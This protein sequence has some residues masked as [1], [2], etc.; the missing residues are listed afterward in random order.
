MNKIKETTDVSNNSRKL[1]KNDFNKKEIS[2]A[3]AEAAKVMLVDQKYDF[4]HT[5]LSIRLCEESI[6][7]DEMD[8]M[9]FVDA[10]EEFIDAIFEMSAIIRGEILEREKTVMVRDG[11]DIYYMNFSTIY[12]ASIINK[13]SPEE[14]ENDL[15]ASIEREENDEIIERIK[16]E[17]KASLNITP[18]QEEQEEA[19][20]YYDS[21]YNGV[22]T[23]L[24]Y[25]NPLNYWISTEA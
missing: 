16:G 14:L 12:G 10:S 9:E 4:K 5:D 22:A 18:W 25:I 3:S 23:A 1:L 19:L 21:A 15:I 20:S 24:S 13:R 6:I 7:K 8:M 17:P 2:S 11:D